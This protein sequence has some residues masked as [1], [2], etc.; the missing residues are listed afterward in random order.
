MEKLNLKVTLLSYISVVLTFFMPLVPLLLLVFFAVV[1]DT[2]AGR[3]YAKKQGKEVLSEITRKGFVNKMFTYGGGLTFIFILDSW[4][5]NDFVMMYFPKEYLSTLFTALFIIWIEYSSIDEK[6]R[7]QT[8]K[9]I[10]ERIFEFVRSIKKAIGV[11]INIKKHRD[12]E[13]GAV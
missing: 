2:F 4:V 12:N 6:V 1:A 3:W 10:T 7:W 9:G 11:I 8:G 13:P 5:L